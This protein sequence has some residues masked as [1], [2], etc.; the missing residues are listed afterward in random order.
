MVPWVCSETTYL[1]VTE[2]CS[3]L[4]LIIPPIRDKRPLTSTMK[5]GWNDSHEVLTSPRNNK[6]IHL[7]IIMIIRTCVVLV[8]IGVLLDNA[9]IKEHILKVHVTCP[10]D[11]YSITIIR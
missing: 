4:L 1:H 10:P 11:H 2:Y 6:C 8:N 9:G 3:S 7:T 5:E